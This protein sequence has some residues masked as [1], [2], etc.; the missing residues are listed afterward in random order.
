M[1]VGGVCEELLRKYEAKN[2]KLNDSRVAAKET[3]KLKTPSSVCCYF[4]DKINSIIKES[5]RRRISLR[6]F[7][8]DYLMQSTWV[9]W[10]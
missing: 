1:I 7:L 9:I 3:N 5:G 8:L 6:N 4:N 10:N 2:A